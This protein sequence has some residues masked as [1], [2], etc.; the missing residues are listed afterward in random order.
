MTVS[1][2]PDRGAASKY[3]GSLPAIAAAA[4]AAPGG[5]AWVLFCDDDQAAPEPL[6][7]DFAS[8]PPD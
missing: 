2:G 7:S 1:V 3:L 5:S 8:P 4:A 6:P